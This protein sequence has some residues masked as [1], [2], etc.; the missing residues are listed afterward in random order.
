MTRSERFYD[1]IEAL[2]D[3]KHEFG[4]HG[5]VNM[6]IEASTTFT[7]MHAETMPEIF[8]GRTGPSAGCYLYG[9]HFNPT[10]YVLGRELAA[11][12][13]TEAAYATASGMAAISSTVLQLCRP[14]DHVVCS[15]TVYGGT[16]ALF[17]D[18]LPQKTGLR[19]SFVNTS[20][21]NAVRNAFHD[22]TRFLYTETLA[23]PTLRVAPIDQLAQI[24]HERGAKLV[25]DNTFSPMIVSPAALGAD[26]V[27]HSLTKYINGA[28]DIVAG[29]ICGK[30][31]FIQSLMDLH[32]GALMLLGPTMDP[33]V[34]FSISLRVPHLGLRMKEHSRRGLEFARRLTTAGYR[35]LYPGLEEHEGYATL[36]RIGRP[37][38][39]A[40]GILALDM[41]TTHRAA[42][43]MEELQ[44]RSFGYM[45]VSLGYF[46]TLMSTSASTT[47]SE[48]NDDAKVQAGL[49][50]G[51]VRLSIGYTGSIEQ[52]WRQM[53]EALAVVE[54]EL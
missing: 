20:D 35:V 15:D 1:P 38:Y 31:E 40:G 27:L 8:Q 13:G 23:N 21:L 36:R 18:F 24:A 4:E 39:G 16:Y 42:R 45:A 50:G 49:T 19:V 29:A 37:E 43:L 10:V 14:G 51:L 22:T 52:R 7:V 9:R 33:K 26:V 32:E 48:M 34:A 2:A 12:E 30:T 5:G 11:L 6:S 41:G 28:S 46:D 17:K 53:E 25:I 47:S 54:Q 3:M 44:N